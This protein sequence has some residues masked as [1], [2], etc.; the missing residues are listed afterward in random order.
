[1]INVTWQDEIFKKN[2][3][4]ILNEK[5]HTDKNWIGHSMRCLL[6]HALEELVSGQMEVKDLKC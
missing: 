2:K 1:M 4:K 6:V 3:T 5:I